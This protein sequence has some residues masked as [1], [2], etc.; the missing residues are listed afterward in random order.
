[1]EPHERV[2]CTSLI[3]CMVVACV[4]ARQLDVAVFGRPTTA[5]N[6]KLESGAIRGEEVSLWKA[7]DFPSKVAAVHRGLARA[8]A[9]A[10]SSSVATST[11]AVLFPLAVLLQ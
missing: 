6:L 4:T 11:L 9:S 3:V 10:Q 5:V 7:H 2:N 8:Q 1:M